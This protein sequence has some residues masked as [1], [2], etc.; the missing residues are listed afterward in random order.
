MI[1]NLKNRYRFWRY[2][3]QQKK[4]YENAI[5]FLDVQVWH[6]DPKG[7][8]IVVFQYGT[9]D[10]MVSGKSAER[11]KDKLEPALKRYPNY[12]FIFLPF[13]ATIKGVEKTEE[14]ENDK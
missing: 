14:P 1:G 3:R 13:Y 10:Y 4:D 11:L 12:T 7:S 6:L 8:G 5:R 2:K 9:P